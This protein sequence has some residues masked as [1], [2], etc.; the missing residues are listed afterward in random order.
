MSKDKEIELLNESLNI[1]KIENNSLKSKNKKLQ[2]I[3][4]NN[5]NNTFMVNNSAIPTFFCGTL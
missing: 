3:N 1:L 4:E 2:K 5:N